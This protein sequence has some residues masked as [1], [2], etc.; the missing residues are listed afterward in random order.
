M[1]KK[2][3][4]QDKLMFRVPNTKEGRHDLI[5][6]KKSLNSDSYRV[7]TLFTGPR[8]KGTPQ[9]STLRENATSIR[10]Y[11]DSKRKEDNI[12]PYEYIQRGRDIERGIQLQ[13]KNNS[14]YHARELEEAENVALYWEHQHKELK[15]QAT[16]LQTKLA[17]LN[18]R[19]QESTKYGKFLRTVNSI[20][21][22][23]V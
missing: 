14:Q 20:K 11:V 12:N 6:I 19:L 7:R 1:I 15:K 4:K 22:V 13:E 2:P 9:A 18:A 23:E 10:V 5:R 17:L 21:E 16:V 8:P 3:V